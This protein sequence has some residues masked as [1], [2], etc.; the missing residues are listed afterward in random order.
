MFSHAA[1]GVTRFSYN[2]LSNQKYLVYSPGKESGA[3]LTKLK[4]TVKLVSS[5]QSYIGF[6]NL[7]TGS[8]I[9][10]QFSFS[11]PTVFSNLTLKQKQEELLKEIGS[12]L[13][14]NVSD[15]LVPFWITHDRSN[16]GRNVVLLRNDG[17]TVRS[18][19]DNLTAECILNR[20]T[21]IQSLEQEDLDALKLAKEKIAIIEKMV[22]LM[23]QSN[24]SL[25]TQY[26][27]TY[28]QSESK[29][30]T[31]VMTVSDSV[32]TDDGSAIKLHR[33]NLPDE[34]LMSQS[35]SF[36]R[37]GEAEDGKDLKDIYMAS[38]TE[39]DFF[40]MQCPADMKEFEIVVQQQLL[41]DQ[42]KRQTGKENDAEVI[43]FR[44]EF[45][46]SSYRSMFSIESGKLKKLPETQLQAILE[47]Y[48]KKLKDVDHTVDGEFS[49]DESVPFVQASGPVGLGRRTSDASLRQSDEEKVEGERAVEIEHEIAA[50]DT[51]VSIPSK[52]FSYDPNSGT[53]NLED[54]KQSLIGLKSIESGSDLE[55]WGLITESGVIYY[56]VFIGKD[57]EEFVKEGAQEYFKG[58]G[59]NETGIL[60]A[61]KDCDDDVLKAYVYDADPDR[62]LEGDEFLN[63]FS[64]NPVELYGTEFSFGVESGAGAAREPS[65]ILEYKVKNDTDKLFAVD[66]VE[67]VIDKT[68]D[69]TYLLSV[70]PTGKICYQS[71]DQHDQGGILKKLRRFNGGLRNNIAEGK[72]FVLSYSVEKRH[73]KQSVYQNSSEPGQ[74]SSFKLIKPDENTDAIGSLFALWSKPA[75]DKALMSGQPAR[76]SNPSVLLECFCSVKM[77][78]VAALLLSGGA[79]LYFGSTIVGSILV[80]GG[81]AILSS[82][83]FAQCRVPSVDPMQ[84][85]PPYIPFSLSGGPK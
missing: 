32:A 20:M 8:F 64:T 74:L 49:D 11:P 73:L 31:P 81:A 24:S 29:E 71:Y 61:I 36:L 47:G 22:D 30:V 6:L 54:L 60:F 42:I 40:Y 21:E 13:A 39:S 15:R 43:I 19:N 63:Y 35:V 41:N 48:T 84:P 85:D 10:K 12:T 1:P 4:S 5:D 56:G 46:T 37:N 26:N 7:Q 70:T 45:K 53:A 62:E 16:E 75:E 79:A 23:S 68:A 80:A 17:A 78:A 55:C 18:I 14:T 76:T 77:V 65:A 27:A 44:A 72:V 9:C 34:E 57:P 38:I 51:E 59:I 50:S 58:Q 69:K 83:M 52:V 67:N 3:H 28:S 2:D 33:I 82:H 66:L 25:I